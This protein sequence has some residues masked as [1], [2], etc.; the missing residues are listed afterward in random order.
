MAQ[1][2][3][4][5]FSIDLTAWPNFGHFQC[6]GIEVE[7]NAVLSYAGG[8]LVAGRERLGQSGIQRTICYILQF[9]NNSVTGVF[10]EAF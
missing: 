10:I 3:N 2:E 4:S 9:F 7:K 5:E 6:F 1:F 8:S